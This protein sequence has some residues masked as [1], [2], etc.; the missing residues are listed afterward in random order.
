MALS[1]DDYENACGFMD[2]GAKWTDKVARFA[3]PILLWAGKNGMPIT[4]TQLAEEIALR[5]NEPIIPRKQLYGK[6]AGKIGDALIG[7][8]DEWGQSLPPVNAILVRQSTGLPGYGANPYIVRHLNERT[9]KRLTESDLKEL[10]NKAM[11]EVWDFAEWDKVARYFGIRKLESV[12]VL[13]SNKQDEEPIQLPKIQPQQGGYTES[14]QHK[15]LKKWAAENPKFFIEFGKFKIGRNE[16]LL[17][18]GD[19]LDA[20]LENN[21][22]KLAVE[23][24]ASN[25][26]DGELFRG[27]FQCVK[28]R[29][30]LRAMQFAVGDLPNA[31]ATLLITRKPPNEVSRLAKKLRVK[32]LLAPKGAE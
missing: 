32:I 1:L 30:T 29:A 20:H 17:M 2:A 24:K 9:K 19:L 25:A 3:L 5:H 16:E 6:P 10:A 15:N 28:Y 23:V 7:L 11:H 18:S 4:Y 8:S 21:E 26:P 12:S 31:Q 22:T 27:V 14:Q 13:L